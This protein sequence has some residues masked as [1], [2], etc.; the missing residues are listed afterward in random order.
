MRFLQDMVEI[1]EKSLDPINEVGE[2]TSR[3]Y[4]C[5]LISRI[6][7]K[8]LN[9]LVTQVPNKCDHI[10]PL[11]KYGGR[12]CI[13]YYDALMELVEPKIAIVRLGD[14]TRIQMIGPLYEGS[15]FGKFNDIPK[16]QSSKH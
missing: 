10:A 11:S 7:Q 3:V 16:P 8:Y 5:N 9:A 6:G 1:F 2:M 15:S 12:G 13:C 4:H 14:T